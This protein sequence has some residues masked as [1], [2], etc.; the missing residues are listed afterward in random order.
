VPYEISSV[1]ETSRF[2]PDKG[3]YTSRESVDGYPESGSDIFGFI[4][5]SNVSMEPGQLAERPRR[6][7]IYRQLPQTVH[8]LIVLSSLA[9]TMTDEDERRAR[10]ELAG[11]SRSTAIST[12]RSTRCINSPAPDLLRLQRLKKRKLQLRDAAS[13]SSKTQITPDIIA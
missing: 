3:V 4:C 13:P 8:N 11:C 10:N 9:Y 5:N 7:D 12:Q 1:G 6:D 2:D